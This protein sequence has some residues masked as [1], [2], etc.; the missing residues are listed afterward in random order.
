[1]CNCT[2][3]VDTADTSIW[4]LH[5][6]RMPCQHKIFTGLFSLQTGNYLG[7][8]FVERSI[9]FLEGIQ[10]GSDASGNF[11]KRSVT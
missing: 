5:E 8:C 3:T 1:V 6:E 9:Y 11:T 7:F 4:R 2:V 10:L